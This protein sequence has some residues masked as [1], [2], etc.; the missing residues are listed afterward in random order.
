MFPQQAF[1]QLEIFAIH[2]KMKHEFDKD[3]RELNKLRK[4][5]Y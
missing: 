2:L 1:L 5:S 4:K 3:M